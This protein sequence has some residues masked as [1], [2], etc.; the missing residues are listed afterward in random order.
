[1]VQQQQDASVEWQSRISLVGG[2]VVA[3]NRGG[4]G[5]S[6]SERLSN[7]LRQRRP[8]DRVEAVRAEEHQE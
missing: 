1:M 8:L 4:T 5:L 6:R 7:L 2:T 3:D